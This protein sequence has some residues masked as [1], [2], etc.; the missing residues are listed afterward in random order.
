MCCF[1]SPAASSSCVPCSG[2]EATLD[3]GRGGGAVAC[4]CWVHKKANVL[5]G[6]Y[7]SSFSEHLKR[8]SSQ[9]RGRVGC[10]ACLWVGSRV[11]MPHCVHDCGCLQHTQGMHKCMLK[12]GRGGGV[13]IFVTPVNAASNPTSTCLLQVHC[14]GN[15][16][17][18]CVSVCNKNPTKAQQQSKIPHRGN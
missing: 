9:W 17:C 11:E 14:Q 7:L 1:F 3:D 13:I 2:T 15:A 8:S 16:V 12:R 6:I 5:G 10:H 18:E 4:W